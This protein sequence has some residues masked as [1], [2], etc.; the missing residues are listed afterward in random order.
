MSRYVKLYMAFL[1]NCVV[2]EMESRGNFFVGML[3]IFCFPLF[4]LLLIGAIYQQTKLLG[5]WTMYEYF[6]LVGTFQ[7]LSAL[8]YTFFMRNIF[9]M[10]EYIRKGELDFYLLKPVNSQFLLSTRYVSFTELS[11]AIPGTILVIIGAVNSNLD[12]E[13]WRWPLYLVFVLC[14]M[15]ITY[16]IWFMMVLPCIWMVKL[17]SIE[18]FF[19]LFDT[20]R[21]HPNMFGGIVKI[22]MTYVLPLGIVAATPA[23]LLTKR[24]DWGGAAWAFVAAAGSLYLSSRFWNFAQSRYY[25]ASS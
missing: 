4:P 11:Q 2:R 19:G 10:P 8:V 15:I 24:L 1:R 25:G 3:V 18:F 13:W 17:D 9:N 14:G 5:G 22:L 6:M 12:I 20:A 21:Y 7:I 23:D 16:A